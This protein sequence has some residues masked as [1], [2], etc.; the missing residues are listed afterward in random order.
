MAK[1]SLS[2][3]FLFDPSILARIV[4]TAGV[5]E[6][7]TVLEVGPG[8]G[9]LTRELLGRGARVVAVEFDRELVKRLRVALALEP[10]FTLYEGDFMKFSLDEVPGRFRTVANIP[11]HITTPIIFK[12]LEQR[13]RLV[14]MTL[15]VQKELAD[16]AAAAPGSK[17][18]GVLSIMLQYHGLVRRAFVIPAG[19]FR[20]APKVD[21]ACLHME[22]ASSPAVDVPDEDEFKNIVRTAFSQRRKTLSNSLKTLGPAMA[23]AFAPAGIDP[24]KRPETLS[25]EEFAALASYFHKFSGAGT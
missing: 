9:S 16:R 14:S 10:R 22:V 19:A 7:D 23:E 18:Y 12:L 25:M 2:Q 11:Y 6:G 15:T 13:Q 8:P 24:S 20:P 1:K 5:G 21:S 3:N 17:S 4:D